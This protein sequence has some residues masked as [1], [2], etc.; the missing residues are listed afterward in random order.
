MTVRIAAGTLKT[1][2]SATDTRAAR[3]RTYAHVLGQEITRYR[4]PTPQKSILFVKTVAAQLP[5]SELFALIP[6]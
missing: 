6:N 2:P 4:D 5:S 1:A 3:M